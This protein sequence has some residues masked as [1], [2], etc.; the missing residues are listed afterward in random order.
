[1]VLTLDDGSTGSDFDYSIPPR[2]VQKF[3]TSN[4]TGRLAVGSVRA[5]PSSGNAA[6]SGLV[7]FS[8]AQ[9]GKTVSEAGV[10][11]LPKG[12]GFR[13]YVKRLERPDRR[14]RSEAGWPYQHG[15]HIQHCDSGGDATRW[16][17]GGRSRNAIASTS[18]QIA[19]FIDEIFTLPGNFAG[20]LRVTSTGDV[21]VV[22]LR[23]R[24]NENGELKM[25]T[26]SP[27]N[28][29][30]PST[31]QDRFFAHL[32]DSEGWST[33]FILFSGTAGQAASGTLSFIGASGQPLDLTT[34]SRVSE[35]LAPP[36]ER[37][38]TAA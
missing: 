29:M 6:P 36:D 30:D 20:V 26:T 27:S 4:P 25:T 23:L 34:D 3:T 17:A 9:D 15:V 35:G 7:V 11:A 18:G 5:T 37:A 22:G 32:A 33:Q 16:I 24:I 2:S 14:V 10:P 12:T 1:M 8:Y 21:A 38:S 28:E 19:R 13:T 31:S